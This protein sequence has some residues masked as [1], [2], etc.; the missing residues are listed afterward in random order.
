MDENLDELFE[1]AS[2]V[3][4]DIDWLEI[5]H[6]FRRITIPATKQLLGVTSDEDVNIVHFRCPRYCGE[7][8]LGD[9]SFRINYMNAGMEGD[10]Y[11]AQDK[12]VTDDTI[13]FTWVV[14]RHPCAYAGS[15]QFIVCAKLFDGDGL[16]IKEY[17][18]MIH[19]LPVLQG[20]ETE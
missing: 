16:V 9:F 19:T 20:L 5:D 2:V 11:V 8:D 17:N 4:Q 7:V 12:E 15:V 10:V 18:T 1:N 6:D 13:T 3:G 14:G